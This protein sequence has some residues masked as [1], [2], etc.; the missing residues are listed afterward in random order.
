MAGLLSGFLILILCGNMIYGQQHNDTINQLDANGRKIGY[1]KKYNE[2]GMILYEGRFDADIPVGEFRYFYPDGKTKAK[3]FFSNNG[4]WSATTTY[5]YSGK[6]MSEGFYLDKKKDSLWKY[7]N[8]NGI[9]LK[10][11]FYRND[12][13]NGIWKTYFQD[14]QVA[15]VTHWKDDKMNGPWI[16]Y[17]YDGTKKLEGSYLNDEK[18]GSV[19]FY[20]P[21]GRT[22]ITG[23]YDQSYRLGTWYYMNDTSQVIKIEYYENGQKIKEENFDPE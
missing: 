16:Q 12:Q 22:R 6:V 4:S 18:Q 10:E 21:S 23:Q 15:E 8:I 11:E 20:F 1:W 9:F 13:K 7:Y 2:S 14:G 17:F 3:S 5:H 19:T